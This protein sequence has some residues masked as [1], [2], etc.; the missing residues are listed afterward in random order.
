MNRNSVKSRNTQRGKSLIELMIVVTIVAIISAFA[1]H[2]YERYVINAKRSVA[3][4]T[5][6]QVAD[7]Q[8]QFFMDNKRFAAVITDL[9]FPAVPYVVV[10][11]GASTVAGY[12]DA[13]Y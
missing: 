1:Y 7:R 9:G 11:V 12:K 2:S 6:L 3:Q 4:N 8:Q 5:L 10:D 13:V